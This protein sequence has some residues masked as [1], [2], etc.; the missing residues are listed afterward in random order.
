MLKRATDYRIDWDFEFNKLRPYLL[1]KYGVVCLEYRSEDAAPEKFNHILKEDFGKNPGNSRWTSIRIDDDWYTTRKAGGILEQ[2][3]RLLTDVGFPPAKAGRQ[4]FDLSVASDNDVGGDMS[5]TM[6]DVNIYI[7]AGLS[8][9][10]DAVC[11]SMRNFIR[12]GGHFMIVVNDAAIRDQ[13]EFWQRIWKAGL[14][15]AC[16]G[17]VLLVIHSGPRSERRRHADS[18][19]PDETLFLPDSVEADQGRHDEMYDDLIDIFKKEGFK[20]PGESAVLYLTNL[21]SSVR[22]VNMRLSAAIMAVRK[23]AGSHES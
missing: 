17:G 2:F 15:A 21:K 20:E 18:P 22:L 8:A 3:E 1:G 14:E 5:I 10:L 9:Q 4:G 6:S 16:E 13:S 19:D 11:E 12:N 7:G 23:S